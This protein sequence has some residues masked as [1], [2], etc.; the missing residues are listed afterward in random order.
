MAGNQ[1]LLGQPPAPAASGS[2]YSSLSALMATSPSD[3]KYTF[4][5]SGGTGNDFE[6]YVI[7]RD[8]GWVKGVSYYNGTDMSGTAAVNAGGSWCDQEQGNYAGKLHSSDLNALMT[9]N[10]FVF[11]VHG[12]SDPLLNDGNGTG[13][14][15]G[16]QSLPN[17]GTAQDPTSTYGLDMDMGTDGTYDYQTTYTQDNRTLCT[18]CCAH[19]SSIWVSDHNYNGSGTYPSGGYHP[20][21]WTIGSTHVH[22]NLHWMGKSGSQSGGTVNFGGSGQGTGFHIFFQ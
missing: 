9:T 21:C 7:T 14:Y 6:A 5:L 16:G 20:Q 8:G 12:S 15:E 19:I 17:W 10:K 4:N 2:G 3:G 22:T 1:I 18:S 13:R 11:R